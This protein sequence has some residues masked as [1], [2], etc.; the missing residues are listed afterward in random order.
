MNLETKITIYKFTPQLFTLTHLTTQ[1]YKSFTCKIY[2]LPG[3]RSIIFALHPPFPVLFHIA[4][5]LYALYLANVYLTYL[6]NTFSKAFCETGLVRKSS[7]PASIALSLSDSKAKAV[8][9]TIGTS[10]E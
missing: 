10:F 3:V 2:N 6:S 7:H 5:C 4:C 1:R 9:A 8:K